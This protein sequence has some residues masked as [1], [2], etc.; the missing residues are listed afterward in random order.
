VGFSVG[1]TLNPA[2][3][4]GW[5]NQYSVIIYYI[6]YLHTPFRENSGVLNINFY[7]SHRIVTLI[8]CS[9]PSTTQSL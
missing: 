8:N 9:V 2:Y 5:E 1:G 7:Q 6:Q 4:Y 3:I